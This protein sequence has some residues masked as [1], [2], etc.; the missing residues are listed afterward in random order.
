LIAPEVAGRRLDSASECASPLALQTKRRRAAAVQDATRDLKPKASN[1]EP[2]AF[3]KIV[4]DKIWQ[5]ADLAINRKTRIQ[6]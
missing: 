6:N 2:V 5:Q 3:G 1:L 4:L